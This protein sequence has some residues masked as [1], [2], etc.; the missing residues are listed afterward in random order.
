LAVSS[1]NVVEDNRK[2]H[3]FIADGVDVEHFKDGRSIGEHVWFADYD[4]VENNDFLVVNQFKVVENGRA[5]RADAV[6]FVNGAPLA[7]FELKN[8]VEEDA[9]IEDAYNQLQ[10]YKAQIPSLFRYNEALIISD[11]INAAVGSLTAELDRFAPWRTVDGETLAPS[12]IL[13]LEVLIKGLFRKDFF[14]DFIRNFCLF[15]ARED[16]LDKKIAA[17]HQF[18]AVKKAVKSAVNASSDKGDKRVGVV[19]HTQGS[20]K[21]LSMIF[22]CRKIVQTPEMENP[23]L[24]IL[25]DLNNLDDQLFEEFVVCKNFLRQTPIQVESRADLKEKLKTTAGGI[26]FTTIQKFS[27]SSEPLSTRRN[28]L[29]IA[30]EAHRSQYDFIDGFARKIRDA[31]PDASFLGFTGTPIE[32][33]DKNTPAVFGNY[34]DIYDVSQAVEDGATVPIY[35]ESRLAK[36]EVLKE[37]LPTIDA[38]FEEIAESEEDSQKVKSKWSRLEVL[39]G[40]KKRVN[41]I[42]NDIVEHYQTRSETVNG[43]AMIVAMSRRICVELYDAIIAIKPEWKENVKIIMTGDASDPIEWQEH[44]YSKKQREKLGNDFR[45]PQNPFKIAIVRD[46]WLTGFNAPCLSVMY[47]DKPMRGHGLM[48]AIARVNR[49][50]SDKQGGLIVDYIGLADNLKKALADYTKRDQSNACI[51]L[52]QAVDVM[53]EKFEIIKGQLHGFDYRKML[54][55]PEMERM[56]PTLDAIEFV[57]KQEKGKERF[58]QAVLELSKAFSLCSTTERAKQIREDLRLFQ[59]MRSL[60]LKTNLSEQPIKSKKDQEYAIRQL[61]SKAVGGSEIIDI[62]KAAGVKSKDISILSDDFLMEVK[63]MKRKNLALELLK[64]LL[65]DEIKIKFKR[66][67][68]KSKKFSE[69]L[70]NSITRY[71]NRL[72]QTVEVIEE[73]IDIA[74]EIKTSEN[75]SEELGLTEEETAFYDALEINDSATKVLGHDVL[76]EMARLLTEKI[77]NSATIDWQTRESVRA[78]LRL[79]VKRILKQ[80]KY[81]PDLEKIA[82]ETVIRQAE[83][84]SGELTTT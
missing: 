70:T 24:V 64:K 42:A 13:K 34:I 51:D 26:I 58:L 27:E 76:R 17:Y 66:N 37:A 35:Y 84:I 33:A 32:N 49:V 68:V 29:V 8:P 36:F 57:L 11:G 50:F 47:V 65:R 25:T 62:L 28:V 2:I 55:K 38:E 31:L 61:V 59:N 9:T 53:A 14:L 45:N 7:V 30:D 4:N 75:K 22:F 72:V 60:I 54:E 44:I 15:E 73:L 71:Q 39:A 16:K 18:Y 3:S 40:D 69:L 82:V 43:K 48:Q 80:Y 46:M 1:Q 78:K 10:T 77:R 52:E 41:L 5:R 19:W 67:V 20:G 63:N 79:E 23:T 6:V 56:T 21:S 81:P 83:V 74:K 12:N